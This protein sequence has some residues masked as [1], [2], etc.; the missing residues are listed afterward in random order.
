MENYITITSLNDFIF[1]PL[2]IF[3][4]QLYGN[5]CERLY[6]EETQINGKAAHES[7]D[8]KRYSTHSNILQG[9]D[10]F[11]DKYNICGKIDIFDVK[12]SQIT[13]RKKKIT[14]VYDGYIFQ[15]YAQYFCLIEMGYEIKTI[16]LY[17]SD[18]N[19]IFPILLPKD[20]LPMFQ[21]FE[22]TIHAMQ[23]FNPDNFM[24]ENKSKC[25]HCI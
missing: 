20:N 6:H 3:F 17:S 4:H 1:C 19:K 9:I 13:E 25:E 22:N 18:T 14:T 15:L 10:V 12:K 21:K 11:C 23:S 16:R 2:S 8:T 24:P 7:I 5:L